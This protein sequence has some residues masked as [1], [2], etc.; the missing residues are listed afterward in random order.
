MFLHTTLKQFVQYAFVLLLLI[1]LVGSVL[2]YQ[3][4]AQPTFSD[5]SASGGDQLLGGPTTGGQGNG[6]ISQIV[7][8]VT[9]NTG[10]GGNSG[11]T[12]SGSG[13]FGGGSS[14]GSSGTGWSLDG[15]FDGAVNLVLDNP[16]TNLIV[17]GAVMVGNEL[18]WSNSGG[19]PATNLLDNTLNAIV[20]NV[21]ELSGDMWDTTSNGEPAGGPMDLTPGG[22]TYNG[23]VI[24]G[25]QTI[26]FA[27]GYNLTLSQGETATINPNGSVTIQLTNGHTAVISPD[28]YTTEYNAQGE[29]VGSNDPAVNPGNYDGNASNSNSPSIP[30]ASIGT[31]GNP[32]SDGVDDTDAASDND[33]ISP[34]ANPY[35]FEYDPSST[36]N[37]PSGAGA[38]TQ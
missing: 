28:G 8:A 3:A 13:W 10:A 26:Q 12:P 14:G 17:D 6:W 11:D 31:V 19:N 29:P 38:Q 35:L 32:F 15:F 25:G 23:A 30:G 16:I 34:F 36:N 24:Q 20:D 22:S 2:P 9:G 21:I 7:N 5:P 1:G 18:G 4:H 27:N 33:P 37:N